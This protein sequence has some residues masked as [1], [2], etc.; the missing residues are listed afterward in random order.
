VALAI[1]LSG[2]IA[3]APSARAA[4]PAAEPSLPAIRA[5][6]VEP[7]P[8]VLEGTNRRQQIV[9]TARRD[10]GTPIDLTRR[11]EVASSDASVASVAGTVV[12]AAGEGTAEIRVRLGAL[13]ATAQAQVR[14]AGTFPP[15]HFANDV[16]P[17]FECGGSPPP[18]TD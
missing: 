7:S 9:V 5:L 18:R 12:S 14:D 15:V 6:T 2:A 3:S 1:V 16:V 10:S 11:C 8:I 17:I 13:S 4:P